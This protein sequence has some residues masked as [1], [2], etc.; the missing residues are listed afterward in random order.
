MYGR[1]VRR[2]LQY[3]AQPTAQPAAA[4][5]KA[6]AAHAA[7][8]TAA[9]PATAQ[10]ASA[11]SSQPQPTATEPESA[12]STEPEPK[13]SSFKS[14]PAA[15]PNAISSQLV[16]ILE[17]LVFHVRKYGPLCTVGRSVPGFLWNSLVEFVLWL[18]RI[19]AELDNP[20]FWLV[21]HHCSRCIR[22]RLAE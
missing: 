12:A 19:L 15:Q 7:S 10:P 9:Q 11:A 21:P 22:K 8:A 16:C 3:A 20:S 13:A 14:K 1:M 17:L 4:A 6:S 2:R 18:K 5:A